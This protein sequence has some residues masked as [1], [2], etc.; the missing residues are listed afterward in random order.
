VHFVLQV[1]LIVSFCQLRKSAAGKRRGGAE[2]LE[3]EVAAQTSVT[4]TSAIVD[5]LIKVD[6]DRVIAEITG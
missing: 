6:A 2:Q 5:G 4:R 1:L 3:A